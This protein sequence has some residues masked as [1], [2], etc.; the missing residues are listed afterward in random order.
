VLRPFV[1]VNMAAT[2]DGKID[3]VERRGARISGSADTAR[4]DRLRAGADAIMVGGHTLLDEDPRLTVRDP[5]LIAERVAAGRPGQPNKIGI[6]SAIQPAGQRGGLPETS[7]FLG[8]GGGRVIIFTTPSTDPGVRAWLEQ[9]RV[10]VIVHA[11]SR[12]DLSLALKT[13]AESGIDRLMV[14][15]GGTLV[16]ALLDAALVDELQL[17]IAPLIFGGQ[18]APT[19]V[20]G[21]GLLRDEAIGL[22]LLGADANGDGGVVLRYRVAQAD[23]A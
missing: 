9:Q 5:D 14:E 18:T 16:A 20:G 6:A 15:G 10:E 13:L 17:T 4:V 3:T 23:A 7:R 21:R 8:E 1:F 12:I 2:A 19:A 22:E 11:G